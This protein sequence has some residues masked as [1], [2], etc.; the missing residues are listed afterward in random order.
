V[1]YIWISIA[2]FCCLLGLKPNEVS[3]KKSLDIFNSVEPFKMDFLPEDVRG[4]NLE[5]IDPSEIPA[6]LKQYLEIKEKLHS[7]DANNLLTLA[8][9]YLY[10]KLEEY[11]K[12]SPYLNE[13]ILG[14]FILEDY[15]LHFQSR[16]YIEMAVRQIE[17]KKYTSSIKILEEA[18][19]IYLLLYKSYPDSPFQSQLPEQLANAERL[20]GDVHFKRKKYKSA[21]QAYRRSLMREFPESRQ[22]RAQVMIS[23][24][25]TYEASGDLEHAADL[26]AYLVKNNVGEEAIEGARSFVE[27]NIK[28]LRKKKVQLKELLPAKSVAKKSSRAI[29]EA[30][31]EEELPSSQ[32]Q[33][34]MVQQF[35][36]SLSQK[37]KL[38][39]LELAHEVLVHVPGIIEARGIIPKVSH[40]IRQYV[41]KNEV[42]SIV[43]QITDLYNAKALSKLGFGLWRDNRP[44]QAAFFYEKILSRFPL[45]TVS[46]HKATFFLGR[47]W[48]DQAELDRSLNMY[49]RVIEKYNYGPYTVNAMFKIPWIRHLQKNNDQAKIEFEGL[50]KFYSSPD[51]DFLSKAFSDTVFFQPASYFWLAMVEGE[52]GQS[53]NKKA[54]L[55]QLVNKYPLDFYSIMSYPELGI[56]LKQFL[57][58]ESS[59]VVAE[60]D[61]GL[62]E[63]GR[64]RLRRAEKLISIGLWDSGAGE[65]ASLA[66]G[67]NNP[68]FLF[69]LS[70]LFEKAGGFQKSIQLTWSITRRNNHQ[71]MSQNLAEALFPKAFWVNAKK[72]AVKNNLDPWLVLSLMRQ[73]SAFNSTVISSAEAVGLM[74][75]LPS[76]AAEVARSMNLPAPA[77]EEL[78][79]PETNILLGTKY[80]SHLLE[81]FNQNV[82]FA[83]AAYNAG[84]NKVESWIKIRKDLPPL[85]F[86]ESIPYFETRA[87][88][89]KV[90]R[91]Y[92]IYL[93][94]YQGKAS[95][96]LKEIL[97][98]SSH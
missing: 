6:I 43:D 87:Y 56:D 98:I 34:K 59:Q 44:K 23:L 8:I 31:K 3:A 20:L 13:N 97:T 96:F 30:Y 55:N 72:A 17:E 84:P 2:V 25:K 75:L 41:Y 11:E 33:N 45:D 92:A 28:Q 48:E 7:R 53:E 67:H 22:H 74:Q 35:Y 63:W 88:V 40:L 62:G 76:T 51:Y 91:N 5:K 42:V 81:Q 86:M 68:E 65:L 15:R 70:Q 95:T 18:I 90:L 16:A 66:K 52:L 64:K 47:L 36:D 89:K 27:K 19:Q 10:L 24:A 71:A 83:L 46:C 73:E 38:K 58:G 93:A 79:N 4:V 14:N 9:A 61:I 54:L 26:F 77:L 50:L 82:I 37:D 60:R 80:L 69:Y 94:L 85:E 39:S 21:W 1:K 78:Q 29:V 32:Y 12:V 57:T 49:K